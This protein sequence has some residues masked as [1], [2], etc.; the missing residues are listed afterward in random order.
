V[1]ARV[2]LGAVV[3]AL[4]AAVLPTSVAASANGSWGAYLAPAGTCA[5][6]EDATASAAMQRRA[7]MCLVNWARARERSGT[8]RTSPA[9][10]RAAVL[11]GRRLVSCGTFSHTPCGSDPAAAARAAGYDYGVFAENLFAATWGTAT[12]RAVVSAWL[13]SPSH[14]VNLLRPGFRHLGAASFR[15]NGFLYGQDAVVWVAAFGSPR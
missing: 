1:G 7:V 14:R 10:T 13:N 5:G 15:A 4:V 11:K 6:A 9:L 2:A 8:L 3:V 12:P